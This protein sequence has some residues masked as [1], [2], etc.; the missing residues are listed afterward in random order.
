MDNRFD[1]NSNEGFI[2]QSFFPPQNNQR[3]LIDIKA[4][5][6]RQ[7]KSKKSKKKKINEIIKGD[8]PNSHITRI[9]FSS[10]FIIRNRN[11]HKYRICKTKI[12][13][14]IA[15]KNLKKK[16]LINQSTKIKGHVKVIN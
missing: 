11:R 13:L 12:T 4:K 7:K 6:F 10:T 8:G 2:F 14:K 9:L 16:E 1:D 15:K 3:S 5:E